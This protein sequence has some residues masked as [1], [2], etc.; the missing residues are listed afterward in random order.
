MGDGVRVLDHGH[1]RAVEHWGSDEGVIAAARMSTGK[2]FLGWGPTTDPC[3]PCGGDGDG[4]DGHPCGPCGG[5]GFRPGDEKLLR[6][7]WTHR[8]TTPFETPGLTVEAAA[9]VVVVW[10]WVRHRTMTFNVL[11]GRYAEMPAEDYLPAA[12]RCLAEGGANRQA[13]RAAG[14]GV[15]TDG[16]VAVWLAR[17]KGLHGHAADV[18]RE[19][20]LAGVPREVARLALTS[21]RYTRLRVTASLL[22]W[23]KFLRLRA[24][25]DAQHEIRVYAEAVAGLL[26]ERFP[27]T[28]ALYDG[29]G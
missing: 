1:V 19:G 6:Y 24:A 26:R 29:G 3:G 27:R 12:A 25:P 18:Y 4:P 28:M 13:G 17:L 5:T 8:H 16:T 20:L 15:P 2:G 9:P 14:A 21:S 23:T 7:L 10:Q 22:N 11:S